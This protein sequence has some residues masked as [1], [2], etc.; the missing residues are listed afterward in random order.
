MSITGF[1]FLPISVHALHSLVFSSISRFQR[2]FCASEGIAKLPWCVENMSSNTV[3][4]VDF[5]IAMHSSR[6]RYP[7]ST[8]MFRHN[9]CM[10]GLI[11]SRRVSA[12]R[13]TKSLTSFRIASFAVSMA[14]SLSLKNLLIVLVRRW[15]SAASRVL[16]EG[17]VSV[18]EF[19]VPWVV[20]VGELSEFISGLKV[21]RVRIVVEV[22]VDL[23]CGIFNN[24]DDFDFEWLLLRQLWAKSEV[25]LVFLYL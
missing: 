4:F 15:S 1:N 9:E 20:F 25:G 5:G 16:I 12:L 23:P 14:R 13:M 21:T 11:S 18:E 6:K 7:F 22:L 17:V 24:V 10:D 2:T 3:S 8:L 19:L